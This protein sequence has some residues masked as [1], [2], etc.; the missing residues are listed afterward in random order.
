MWSLLDLLLPPF[1]VAAAGAL[2]LVTL[3][4]KG[5]GGH[6]DVDEHDVIGGRRDE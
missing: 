4:G 5:H 2:A 1:L 3:L 6:T